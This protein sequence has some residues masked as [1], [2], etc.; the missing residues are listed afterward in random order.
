MGKHCISDGFRIHQKCACPTLRE[1]ENIVNKTLTAVAWF[2]GVAFIGST[3]L[4]IGVVAYCAI[5]GEMITFG[6]H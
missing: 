4:A 2:Y 1:K 3:V 6:D 5:T